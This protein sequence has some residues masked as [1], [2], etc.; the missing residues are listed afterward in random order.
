MPYPHM[1]KYLSQIPTVDLQRGIRDIEENPGRIMYSGS[2]HS[3]DL[4]RY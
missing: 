3:A 2:I 1:H 4:D